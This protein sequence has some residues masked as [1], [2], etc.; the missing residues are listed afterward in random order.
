MTIY[1]DYQFIARTV[2]EHSNI[3]QNQS[4]FTSCPAM[5]QPIH[6]ASIKTPNIN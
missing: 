1:L 2:T 6:L 5:E 3:V 4:L